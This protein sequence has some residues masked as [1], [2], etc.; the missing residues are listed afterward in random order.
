MLSNEKE[1][2]IDT[3]SMQKTDG[4]QK[5]YIDQCN[6]KEANLKRL[7]IVWLHFYDISMSAQKMQN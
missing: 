5:H 7:H 6:E 4:P 1:Q 2:I 3:C